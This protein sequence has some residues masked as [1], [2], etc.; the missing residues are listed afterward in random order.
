M[1][2]GAL[3]HRMAFFF[4]P[5]IDRVIEMSDGEVWDR[6]LGARE[7]AALMEDDS[8]L[9]PQ[10]AET[11]LIS[12]ARTVIR[13]QVAARHV[14]DAFAAHMTRLLDVTTALSDAASTVDV[15]KVVIHQGLDALEATGGLVAIIDGEE[16]RVLDWRASTEGNGDPASII[17]IGDNGP[18]AEALRR[19]EPVWLESRE[20]FGELFPHVQ[21]RL[22][23]G[24]TATAILALP[25]LHG[26][27]LVGALVVG[28]DT[29]SAF[30][31]TNHGF[32]ILLAQS[33][34][35]AL[36]RAGVF[37]RERDA[38]RH[39]ETMSRAREEVLGVVAHD[40]RNPL[41]V[42]GGTIELL[43]EYDLAPHQR[44]NLLAAAARGVQQMKRLVNDLLD[45]TRLENGRLALATEELTAETLL[46]DAA[47]SIR[48]AALE[49]RILLTV[50]PAADDLRVIGD[51][52]RLAQVF[53]NLLG[54]AAKFTPEGGRVT[55]RSWR[56]SG[57]V[58]FEVAD[59][60][61]GVSPENRE[62]LFDR[63]WQAR[64]ADLRGIG[65]GLAISKAIVE[66]HGGRMWV[67]SEVGAGSR[68]CFAV[69]SAPDV[70]E[71]Q[72][73]ADA[74]QPLAVG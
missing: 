57:E 60:G 41:G 16:L 30:G 72:P 33:T 37:E 65:L 47:D 12:I 24:I 61:P 55:L 46:A 39:A 42:I 51:R 52:G 13:H 20:Q 2:C 15:A 71:G 23:P 6:G 56:E 49:R 11:S 44:D 36:A 53:D 31:A 43:S 10:V 3:L 4:S 21:D 38:R 9:T 48:Q 66:A 34:A 70:A 50:A 22:P 74:A 62:H 8:A 18:L 29:T 5:G 32:P 73:L 59:T 19:R 45:V 54:N 68:F 64:A 27:D 26:P 1:C 7:L 63:F 69:P 67:D 14:A 40:L 17:S 58:V 28:F 35:A 25:L